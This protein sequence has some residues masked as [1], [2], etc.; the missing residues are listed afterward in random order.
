M[1]TLICVTGVGWVAF[2]VAAVTERV[3]PNQTWVAMLGLSG[4]AVMVVCIPLIVGVA[5]GL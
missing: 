5:V 4:V 1:G 3:K 2:M